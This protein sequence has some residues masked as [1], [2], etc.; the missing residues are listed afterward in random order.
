ME[1]ASV[2]REHAVTGASA[3]SGYR[4]GNG[5]EPVGDTRVGLL[6]GSFNPAHEGHRHISLA[7]LDRLQLDAVWWMVSPQNP[8]KETAGMAAYEARMEA[9]QRVA[10]HPDIHVTD[11]ERELGTVHTIDTITALRR[12]F[13]SIRFVWLM[14]ADN[15]IQIPRWKHWRRLFRSVPI[16]VF[17]RPTYSI[18]AFSGVAAR[19]FADARV[20]QSRARMLADMRAP[21]WVFIRARRHAASA[22]RIRQR[23]GWAD[24]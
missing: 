20:P 1:P 5:H 24:A 11:I 12:R 23:H 6:G 2:V 3:G 17:P 8:L 22:T 14:G 9:A 7:A 19:V 10:D 15:L 13:E 21:A 18:R 16:A 4:N